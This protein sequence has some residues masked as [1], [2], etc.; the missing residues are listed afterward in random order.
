MIR[1]I[2]HVD[3]DARFHCAHCEV[4]FCPDCVGMKDM[5][6][7]KIDLC[8]KC[9]NAVADLSPYL[10]AKP[11]W[12][13]IP[14]ILFYPFRDD[15]PMTLAGWAIFSLVILFIID[16]SQINILASIGGIFFA[17]MYASLLITYFYRIV[18][19]AEDGKFTIPNFSNWDGILTAWGQVFQFFLSC[20]AAF[21]PLPILLI[22][23]DLVHGALVEAFQSVLGPL[24]ILLL[25]IFFLAGLALLPM[26][27]LVMGVFRS[28][29]LVFNYVFLVKQ[30][31]KIP[32]EYSIMLIFLVGLLILQSLASGMIMLFLH[33]MGLVGGLLSYPV[34]GVVNLYS[35]MVLG[36]LLGYMAYQTRFKLKWWPDCQEE[37]AFMIQGRPVL[38]SSAMV[39]ADFAPQPGPGAGAAV[40]AAA[41]LAGGAAASMGG[42]AMAGQDGGLEMDV[43][44][45]REINDGMAMLEHGRHG[46]ALELFQRVL[47]SHPNHPGALRGAAQAA[48]K[49]GDI[50]TAKKY[51]VLQG[52]GLAKEQSFESLHEMYVETR[53]FIP[54]LTLDNRSTMALSKWLIDTDKAADAAGVLREFAVRDPDDPLAPKALYQC[55][56]LLRDKLGK[57][58]TAARMFEF[59][60]KKYPDVVFADQIEKALAQLKKE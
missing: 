22:V 13:R 42:Q 27:L 16:I 15:G 2:N 39:P 7:I 8:P 5:G 26:A 4:A 52:K 11:F 53:K 33:L 51:A 19:Q 30:A 59:I 21:L 32:L 57:P 10:P 37:P 46:D 36:Q 29:G 1:C 34:W 14:E 49:L 50:E 45:S 48:Q 25:V 43:E 55:G 12:E 18:S 20:L 35:T 40:A 31:M 17:L 60:L 58:E 56:E 54:D 6:R 41:V 28:L 24:Y 38:P 47:E 3:R 23:M 9:K 44:L